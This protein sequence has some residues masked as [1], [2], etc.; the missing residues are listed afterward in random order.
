MERI[1][2]LLMGKASFP[3][4]AHSKEDEKSLTMFDSSRS[5]GISWK[6]FILGEF[7]VA[8]KEDKQRC[9]K[10]IQK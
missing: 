9:F 5:N 4:P 6:S 8:A 10:L 1:M 2:R 3:V 7:E